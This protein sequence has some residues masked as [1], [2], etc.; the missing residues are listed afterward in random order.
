MQLS[1]SSHA[2]QPPQ[3]WFPVRVY[4]EDTD[5]GGVVFHA[6]YVKFFERAR[7]EWLRTK[8][9]EQRTLQETGNG[10]FVVTDVRLSYRA[11]AR[12]DDLLQV[13]VQLHS[14]GNASLTLAQQVQ[15]GDTLLVSG[16]VRVG[17]VDARTLRPQRIP[18]A[19]ATALRRAG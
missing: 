16:Q 3:T 19:L 1:D 15:R 17:Y 6:N 8:G 11:P 12:L 10:A 5:A 14:L 7:T 4:W 18:A 2:A 9:I 13:A